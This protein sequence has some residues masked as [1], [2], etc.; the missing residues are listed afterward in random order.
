MVIYISNFPKNLYS[1]TTVNKFTAAGPAGVPLSLRPVPLYITIPHC[2]PSPL[3]SC[4]SHIDSARWLSRDH[5]SSHPSLPIHQ[6]F[7]IR[8]RSG[9]RVPNPL[10]A[11]PQSPIQIT[12]F[13]S[14]FP[15]LTSTTSMRWWRN[16]TDTWSYSI[17]A[18]GLSPKSIIISSPQCTQGV[19]ESLSRSGLCGG[20]QK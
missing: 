14:F 1:S 18:L 10:P 5:F 12:I 20:V 7:H 3:I 19:G 17:C 8:C 6:S 16:N 11:Q 2:P 9:D 4:Q 13:P 15:L